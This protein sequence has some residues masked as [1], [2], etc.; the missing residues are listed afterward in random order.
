MVRTVGLVFGGLEKGVGAD[1]FCQAIG[2]DIVVQALSQP[3]CRLR[4]CSLEL[5]KPVDQLLEF[6]Y[7]FL[8]CGI[9]GI[10]TRKIPGIVRGN[11]TALRILLHNNLNG[12][13]SM[14]KAGS[15]DH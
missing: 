12:E 15:W 10:Q 5:C 6:W 3:S 7:R 2:P 14:V 11:L 8:P 4:K 13:I 9:V 1:P